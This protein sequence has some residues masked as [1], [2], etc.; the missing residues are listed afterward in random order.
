MEVYVNICIRV[1]NSM[2][3]YSA[4]NRLV[5]GSSPRQP[6]NITLIHI[7]NKKVLRI[8]KLL[9]PNNY[10]KDFYTQHKGKRHNFKKSYLK[11]LL[12]E[13]RAFVIYKNRIL[14]FLD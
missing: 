9:C 14:T 2:V 10:R 7:E 6:K 8:P 3:E 5:L 13:D 12:L 1:A 11:I 4:F